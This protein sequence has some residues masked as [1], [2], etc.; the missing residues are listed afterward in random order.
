MSGASR[1]SLPPAYAM[2]RKTH[3]REHNNSVGGH[4]NGVPVPALEYLR[5]R[6]G[7]SQRELAD[8]AGVG[9]YT[10][11]RLE[12]G[13]NARYDTIEKLAA[14]LGTTRAR[15]IQLPPQIQQRK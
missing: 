5:K 8:R 9:R 13:A 12:Q 7:L 1:L 4:A 11:S 15:L 10:I 2:V 3:V 6:A 14:A